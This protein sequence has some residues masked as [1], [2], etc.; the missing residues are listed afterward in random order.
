MNDT[1]TIV[2]T[3]G[4]DP[5]KKVRNGVP[6]TTFRVASKERRFD[7]TQMLAELNAR[8]GVCVTIE[9]ES[10]PFGALCAH[11]TRRRSFMAD[12]V[13]FLSGPGRGVILIKLHEEDG[14][15][16]DYW[17][18]I[19]ASIVIAIDRTL[20][21]DLGARARERGV[22]WGIDLGISVEDLA[23]IIQEAVAGTLLDSAVAGAGEGGYVTGANRPDEHLRG[24]VQREVG[25]DLQPVGAVRS[26]GGGAGCGVGHAVSV[27]VRAASDAATEWSGLVSGSECSR[28]TTRLCV[29]SS[30]T[31]PDS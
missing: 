8:S 21:P 18:K 10:R 20:R 12:E 23:T 22:E 6:I 17:V 19:P 24:V 1:I 29:P 16:L 30:K 7:R 27:P 3:V 11:S 15:D 31:E 2:G 5:E 28:S 26:A 9:G 4:T 25:A 14:T 13:N